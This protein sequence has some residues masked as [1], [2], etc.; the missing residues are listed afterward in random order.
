MLQFCRQQE[1]TSVHKKLET[2][3]AGPWKVKRNVFQ[4]IVLETELGMQCSIVDIG[5]SLS[6]S[7]EG[8]RAAHPSNKKTENESK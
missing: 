8:L 4:A 7:Q 1:G 2:L 6:H 3:C 5:S